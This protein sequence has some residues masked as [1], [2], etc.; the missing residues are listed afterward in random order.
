[1]KRKF[2]KSCVTASQLPETRKITVFE[3]RRYGDY[4]CACGCGHL[5][6]GMC[7]SVGLESDEEGLE[8][9]TFR[10][11]CWRT[12]SARFTPGQIYNMFETNECAD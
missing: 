11:S 10:R 8:W 9:R 12:L 1:M 5:L 7:I 4:Y 2:T 6:Q 3:S